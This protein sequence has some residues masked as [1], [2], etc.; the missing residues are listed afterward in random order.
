[1]E[2]SQLRY[3]LTVAARGN[4]SRAAEELGLSQPALSRAIAKLEEELGQPVFERKPRSVALTDAGSRLRTCAQEVLA[5]IDKA[6]SEITDDGQ[7]G[8]IRIAAIPTI[9]PYFLP[10]VLR[11]FSK[12]YP[13]ANVQ[14]IEDVTAGTLRRCDEG[15]VDLGIVALPI[16]TKYLQVEELF[17]EELLVVLPARHALAR[18]TRITLDDLKPHPFVLLDEAH[19]L[20][21]QI[22]SYCRRRAIQPVAME[23]TSQL[24]TVQELVALGHGVSMVPAMAQRLDTS[25]RRT[26]RSL[27]GPIPTRK[28]A[29]VWNPYRFQ[30]R[31]LE[32]FKEV[33]RGHDAS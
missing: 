5:I 8:T 27:A 3:F 19:C 30:S 9:A 33:L 10:G 20:C 31:L 15:D 1:V 26:Y 23:R 18:K 4:F 29:M 13:R 14:V 28:I 11:A 7:T 6:K 12:L 24:T 2:L 22:V 17:E 32:A 16:T 25:K 21:D